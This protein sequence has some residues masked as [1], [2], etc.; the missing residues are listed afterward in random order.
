MS[1]FTLNMNGNQNNIANVNSIRDESSKLT[2][3]NEK[4]RI[5]NNQDPRSVVFRDQQRQ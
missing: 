1:K 4:I 5:V 2:S 3:N